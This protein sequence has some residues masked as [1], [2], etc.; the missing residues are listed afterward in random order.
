MKNT[1]TKYSVS[2]QPPVGVWGPRT[3]QRCFRAS[4]GHHLM[5]QLNQCQLY[6]VAL[7]TL[8]LIRP[9]IVSMY[10]IREYG[11]VCRTYRARRHMLRDLYIHIA[12]SYECMQE[13][14]LEYLS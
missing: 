12:I 7:L 6:T 13:Y 3:T 11:L 2:T 9:P 10:N 8:Y 4:L 5:V 1:S 14:F